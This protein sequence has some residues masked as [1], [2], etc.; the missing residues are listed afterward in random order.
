MLSFETGSPKILTEQDLQ[1]RSG[2][3]LVR[4]PARHTLGHGCVDPAL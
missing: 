1:I 2:R 3:R 4:L